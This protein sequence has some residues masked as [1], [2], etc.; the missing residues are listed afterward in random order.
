LESVGRRKGPLFSYSV[1]ALPL[2]SIPED[3]NNDELPSDRVNP[4]LADD[5]PSASTSEPAEGTQ[6]RKRDD[7]KDG[8]GV[9][10]GLRKKHRG[11]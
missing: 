9:V 2:T 8:H 1:A 10:E 6:K 7:S 4:G 3:V 5:N 11:E